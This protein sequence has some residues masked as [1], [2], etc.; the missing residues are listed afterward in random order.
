LNEGDDH[1]RDDDDDVDTYNITLV[2]HDWI[3]L[4]RQGYKGYVTLR[5]LCDFKPS[6]S[7]VARKGIVYVFKLL[8]V[9]LLRDGAG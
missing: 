9:G 7:D 2:L 8:A 4:G 6:F 5:C 3:D 1:D